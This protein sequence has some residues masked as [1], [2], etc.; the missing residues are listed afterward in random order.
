MILII[1][2][3]EARKL[4]DELIKA[5]DDLESTPLE[6][7]HGMRG[8]PKKQ[9]LSLIRQEKNPTSR[10]GPL[11]I[12][13]EE[14]GVDINAYPWHCPT[15]YNNKYD[16][17]DH[18]PPLTPF[19]KLVIAKIQGNGI[20]AKAAALEVGMPAA[21]FWWYLRNGLRKPSPNLLKICK[22]AEIPADMALL[23]PLPP[24]MSKELATVMKREKITQQ[25]LS[26][27]TGVGI[28]VIHDYLQYETRGSKRNPMSRRRCGFEAI[29]AY[30][31]REIPSWRDAKEE[32]EEVK[33]VK[34][35]PQ[36]PPNP[37]FLAMLNK[38]II[39]I[40]KHIKHSTWLNNEIEEIDKTIGETKH[41]DEISKLNVRKNILKDQICFETK[42]WMNLTEEYVKYK[43]Q[44]EGFECCT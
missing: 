1:S 16:T 30:L 38:K 32:V 40:E 7:T 6:V 26:L 36:K 20:T 13:A 24:V 11:E 28:G 19:G 9:A 33:E 27:R 8:W 2:A 21:T 15:K 41:D 17:S 23:P 3:V 34:A 14:L 18:R 29:E 22:W 4:S 35:E 37:K 42:T 25:K 44:K 31:D 5:M 39:E 12:I 43:Q 10:T